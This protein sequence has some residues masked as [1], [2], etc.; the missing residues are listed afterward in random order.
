MP[1]A[2]LLAAARRGSLCWP[3]LVVAACIALNMQ[4]LAVN[5]SLNAATP[6]SIIRAH[7]WAG[8]L[9]IVALFHAARPGVARTGASVQRG[10][11]AEIQVVHADVTGRV[12]L[13]QAREIGE[14]RQ[15]GQEK[16]VLD[17]LSRR[18]KPSWPSLALHPE[19]RAEQPR[20]TTESARPP[21]DHYRHCSSVD[22]GLARIHRLSFDDH[23]VWVIL[24]LVGEGVPRSPAGRL[25]S[26]SPVRSWWT[27]GWV[28][29]A[30]AG[31][32]R[33]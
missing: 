10:N 24:R 18:T 2:V 14:L 7:L 26:R 19:R 31:C 1:A 20:R 6:D 4:P 17:R 8:I 32:S 23:P 16:G 5:G 21:V 13:G 11:R 3:Y 22:R 25:C 28:R 9:G 33:W 12:H 29:L 27:G 30:A 15:P